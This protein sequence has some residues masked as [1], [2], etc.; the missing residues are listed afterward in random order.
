M[1]T[2]PMASGPPSLPGV[3]LGPV[4]GKVTLDSA[5]ILIE[6]GTHLCRRLNQ[7]A[8]RTQ[9][10]VYQ[11]EM[12]ADLVPTVF[13]CVG[14][15]PESTYDYT[16][17]YGGQLIPNGIT[18]R[19]RTLPSELGQLRVLFGSCDLPDSRG[20]VDMFEKI[21]KEYVSAGIV[22]LM[23]RLGDQIYADRCASL[24]AAAAAAA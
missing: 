10:V 18:G 23:L 12:V 8:S 15:L 16:F 9:H 24:A 17:S 21:Y 5:R 14:L 1:P 20:P 2:F 7:R 4:L 6:F 3:L 11:D 19:L 13:V 22:D